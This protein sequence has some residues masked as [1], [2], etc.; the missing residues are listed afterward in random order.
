MWARNYWL[1]GLNY[2]H[3]ARA[4][5]DCSAYLSAVVYADIWCQNHRVSPSPLSSDVIAVER[6][7]S[8]NASSNIL[9]V[10]HAHSPEE[11]AACQAVLYEAYQG[12]FSALS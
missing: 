11:G 6:A 9:E 1:S 12:G 7:A 4:A 10:I 8:A 3:V 2:L 5:L